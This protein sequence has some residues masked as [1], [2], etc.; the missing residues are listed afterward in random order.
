MIITR[1]PHKVGLLALAL[2]AGIVTACRAPQADVEL[3]TLQRGACFGTCPI[4]SLSVHGDGRV[5]YDGLDF[6]EV[7]GVQTTT[8][9]AAAVQELGDTMAE[10]GYF[11]WQDAYVN[12]E[13]TDLPS[14]VTSITLSDGTTKRIAHYYGDTSAPEALTEL[15]RL[16]DETANTAQWV[17]P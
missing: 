6:V 9:D 8:I 14:A 5:E 11:D 2:L 16:I 17:G 12:Q 10:A 1:R 3:I 13:I 7:T 4:Y 15:E